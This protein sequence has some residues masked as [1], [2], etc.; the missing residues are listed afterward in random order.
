ML[1]FKG[2]LRIGVEFKRADAPRV[3]PS[4]NIAMHDL[5]LD[6]LYVV[7]PGELRYALAERMEA[8]PLAALL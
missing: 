8:V 7:Y 2:G 6:H 1:L 3:T 5:Q 4:M